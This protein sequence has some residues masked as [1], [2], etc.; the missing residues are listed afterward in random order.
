MIPWFSA[1]L[2]ITAIRG[3]HVELVE[4]AR[5]ACG[6]SGC[7]TVFVDGDDIVVQGYPVDP[8]AAGIDLPAGETLVRIPRSLVRDASER[9]SSRP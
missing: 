8:A 9:L 2:R 4:V 5:F 1:I 6:S 7:P 3:G